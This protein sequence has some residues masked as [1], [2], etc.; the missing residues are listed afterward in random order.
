MLDRLRLRSA[1]SPRLGNACG[2]SRNR[3]A[4]RPTRPTS[5]DGSGAPYEHPAEEID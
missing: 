2:S 1:S 3:P 5:F 4:G